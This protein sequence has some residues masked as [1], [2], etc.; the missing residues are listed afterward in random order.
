[1]LQSYWQQIGVKA[2]I[3]VNEWG[4][5]SDTVCS[6][7]SDVY[8]MSWS[9]YPDPYFFLD[10]LFSS[11][12]T[13]AIGNGAGYV[14]EYVE[15]ELAAARQTTDQ[16]ERKAHYSNAMKQIMQDYTGIYYANP[17]EL[18]GI[19]DR[20]QDFVPRADGQLFFITSDDGE[21][22]TRNTSVTD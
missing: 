13:T 3:S 16:E 15:Q 19:N 4:T 17:Y 7:N 20:V 5:F 2:H 18:T 11:T 1:M 6:G 8:A 21:T 14:N 22:I 9:W 12:E 10:K